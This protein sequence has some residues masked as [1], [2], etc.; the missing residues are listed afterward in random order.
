MT[1]SCEIVW[2]PRRVTRPVRGGGTP[3][4]RDGELRRG[5][6]E[7]ETSTSWVQSE[8]DSPRRRGSPGRCHASMR[9]TGLG[10]DSTRTAKRCLC[11]P[12]PPSRALNE[13]KRGRG[14]E[15]P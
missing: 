10:E 6:K 1:L 7:E 13:H 15:D 11:F 2:S 3:C 8:E 5:R 4:S 9:G 14:L 12:P